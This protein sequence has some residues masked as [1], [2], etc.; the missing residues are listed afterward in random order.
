MRPAFNLDLLEA[1]M[2]FWEF[3]PMGPGIFMVLEV[4]TYIGYY[5]SIYADVRLI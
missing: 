3:R 5:Y 4:K 1:H 2:K